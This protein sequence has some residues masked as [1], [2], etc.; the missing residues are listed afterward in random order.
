METTPFSEPK[1][2]SPGYF[3]INYKLVSQ[4]VVTVPVY[5]NLGGNFVKIANDPREFEDVF[6]KKKFGDLYIPTEYQNAFYETAATTYLN[7]LREKLNDPKNN[8]REVAR[9]VVDWTDI[10]L[11]E[12]MS[13]DSNMAVKHLQ[14]F[15]GDFLT[16]FKSKNLNNLMSEI[17]KFDYSTA[18]HSIE[19]MMLTLNYFDSLPQQNRRLNE[20]GAMAALLHDVGKQKVDPSIILKPG[21]LTD[22]EY[23]EIKNHPN[24]GMQIIEGIDFKAL[25]FNEAEKKL[26]VDAVM[27]HHEREDGS[28]YPN[29]LKAEQISD[30]GKILAIIDVYSAITSN[31]RPYREGVKPPVAINMIEKEVKEGKLN[32]QFFNQF[33]LSLRSLGINTSQ[34]F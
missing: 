8:E 2:V 19:A 4:G 28:G 25:G 23:T 14:T 31:T 1:P 24:Y 11:G 34:Q 6:K 16:G 10:C 12:M 22:A 30:Y 27:Q 17:Q 15:V 9:L 5:R 18:Q 33:I 3:P 20:I 32:G 26:I 29:N 21:Q 7:N 13:A